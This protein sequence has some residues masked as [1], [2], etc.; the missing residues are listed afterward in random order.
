[1]GEY[2]EM[3][4]GGVCCERCGHFIGSEVGYPQTCDDCHHELT[5]AE[6]E[7]EQK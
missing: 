6:V 5:I 2:A 4:I 3:M 7:E 1:M